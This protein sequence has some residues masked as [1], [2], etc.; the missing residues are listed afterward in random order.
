MPETALKLSKR[1]AEALADICLRHAGELNAFLQTIHQG[2][3]AVDL[4]IAKT[5]IGRI[6]GETYM[7]ALHPIFERYPEL[8]PTDFS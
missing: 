2:N 8:K 4:E 1:S 5:M 3:S 7:A 6:M